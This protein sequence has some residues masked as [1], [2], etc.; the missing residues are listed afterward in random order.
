MISSPCLTDPAHYAADA[1]RTRAT[2]GG[3]TL[4]LRRRLAGEAY[5]RTAAYD[6]AIAA[7]FAAPAR[8]G[9]PAAARRSR[10][11]CDRRCAT[12]RTRTSTRR[13][14][15]T[16]TAPASPPRGRC[17]ARSCPTTTSTTPTRRSSASPNSPTPTVVIIKHANPC[18]VASAPTLAAA[19][20]AALRC[21]PVSAFG[22]IVA[23]QPHAGRSGGRAKSPA[24][25]TEVIIAPDA[26][27]TAPGACSRAR[28]TCACC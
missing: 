9:I 3:T 28:R 11:R 21:D 17:R 8:R 6:A 7:W 26:T 4:A 14:T 25:F 16:A 18:G 22:G 20:D 2:H 23:R 24:I 27:P 13:S 1:G 5:A 19:W 10:A 15:S 12:A